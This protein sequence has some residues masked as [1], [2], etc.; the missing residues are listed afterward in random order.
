MQNAAPWSQQNW[1]T[2]KGSHN[3]YSVLLNAFSH[4]LAPVI[5]K[6]LA[7]SLHV[8]IGLLSQI[9]CTY[10]A[11]SFSHS[12]SREILCWSWTLQS[13]VHWH[14][15]SP[16][17]AT[18]Q[19]QCSFQFCVLDNP[20]TFHYSTHINPKSTVIKTWKHSVHISLTLNNISHCVK[21]HPLR[22]TKPMAIC[23]SRL[24]LFYN[25]YWKSYATSF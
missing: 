12:M 23:R 4:K 10:T 8:A 25:S 17:Y 11:A 2:S 19:L 20:N 13:G 1:D 9:N 7:V 15:L 14:C 3:T 21:N 5:W 6:L 22:D 18:E 24:T 16:S